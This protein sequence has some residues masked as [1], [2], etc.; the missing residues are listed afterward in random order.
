MARDSRCLAR[1][2]GIFI[3]ALTQ[4]QRQSAK[5][6]GFLGG[7][8]GSVTVIQRFGGSANLNI[9]FHTIMIEGVYREDSN[10]MA[11]FHALA[12][13]NDEDVSRLLS[14]IQSRVVRALRRMGYPVSGADETEDREEHQSLLDLCQGASVQNRIAVGERAG[15]RVRKIGS[16]GVSGEPT[17]SQG[18]RCVS[19][20]GFS[21]HANTAVE[22][23]RRDELEKLLRYIARP[24]IAEMRL[25]EARDGGI[26]YR[27][28]REWSDGTQAVYFTP[29]EFIE[30]LVAL[31]PQPRIHLT[32]FH[33]VLAPNSKLRR[34]VVP[35]PLT[36]ESSDCEEPKSSDKPEKKARDPRR[37]S[38]AEL[39]KR[40]FQIEITECPDCGG[41]L[42]FIA[43]V[44][45]RDAV[46][47]ILTHL[48][49]SAELPKFY[50]ARAPPR[51]EPL[52]DDFTN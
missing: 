50:P 43:A 6:A 8:S 14:Q 22:T 41:Q 44:L 32:R 15:A 9:H 48:G 46:E 26:V 24:A 39:L 5:R 29:L 4:F 33:G 42:L 27:F 10:K 28:K 7:E 37:L 34:F 30:K 1:V 40:V 3:R 13:P 19:I 45:K 23:D 31:V 47:K 25:S 35:V 51:Q 18:P 2:L 38:W 21:L 20:G 36:P 12:P 11:E 17:L 52:F 49:R 16:F